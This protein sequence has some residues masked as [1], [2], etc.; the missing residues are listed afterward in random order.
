MDGC[1]R[2]S[3]V[4]RCTTAAN[5][6]GDDVRARG[7]VC[8]RDDGDDET[9]QTYVCVYVYCTFVGSQLSRVDLI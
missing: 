7:E 1:I 2:V 3:G 6:K 5:G 8:S 9:G 4:C